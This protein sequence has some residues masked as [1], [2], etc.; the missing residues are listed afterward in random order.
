MRQL[1]PVLIHGQF[2]TVVAILSSLAGR[3]F[4]LSFCGPDLLS[5]APVWPIRRWV[6][7]LL[8]NVAALRASAIICKS[9]ELRQAL[10]WRQDCAIIIP[11]GV[12]LHLFSPGSQDAARTEL[13]W[14]LTDPTVLVVVRDDPKNKGLDLA[15]SSVTAVRSSLPDVKLQVVTNVMHHRMPLYY[16]AADVLLCTSKVEG[17][18]NVIKEA[19]ACNLP[20]VSVPV[21]DVQERLTGVYPSAIVPRH[22]S[23]ISEAFLKILSHRQR[24]NGR[25]QIRQLSLEQVAQKILEVYRLVLNSPVSRH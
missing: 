13:G 16:R 11:N 24:S 25:E 21:G 10:W 20:V 6:G 1:N 9:E 5:G 22:S 15:T 12:D 14:S 8:S 19:L 2:G 4:V 23:P 3:A 17:S 18:P 7:H